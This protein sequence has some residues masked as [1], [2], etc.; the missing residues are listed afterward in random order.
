MNPTPL[1]YGILLLLSLLLHALEVGLA[2]FSKVSLAG[3]I[4]DLE[5]DFLNRFDFIKKH[6]TFLNT[7]RGTNFILKGILIIWAYQLLEWQKPLLKATLI[8]GFYFLVYHLFIY[9]LVISR[10]ARLLRGLLYLHPLPWY[11]FLPFNGFIR[12]VQRLAGQPVK[13]DNDDPSDKEREVFIDEGAKAGVIEHEDREMVASVLEF[14]D[15]LVK[16]IMTPRVDMY[17]LDIKTPL[18]DVAAFIREKK[19]SRFP[20]VNGRIDNIEG[21]VL[22]KDIF[23]IIDTPEALLTQVLRP[24]YFVPETMR[25]QDLLKEMQRSRQKFA[26]V[27]DEFGGVSGLVTMEDIMEEI[28]GDIQDEYDNDEA[29]IIKTEHGYIVRGDTDVYELSETL[30]ISLSDDEDYQTVTG[31]ISYKLGRIATVGDQIHLPPY[32]AEVLSVEKTRIH[33]VKFKHE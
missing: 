4:E 7:L 23:D 30:G 32:T 3:Y 11:L 10:R 12:T 6:S 20:V 1:I 5:S 33:K 24:P 14:G 28:V 29:L 2:G 31:L 15:T 19:K 26:V 18:S 22:A 21:I 27:A 9:L 25:I 8:I 16:E 13:I 17:Y